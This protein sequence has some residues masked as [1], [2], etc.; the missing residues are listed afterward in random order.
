MEKEKKG[1]WRGGGVY[2]HINFKKYQITEISVVISI[3]LTFELEKTLKR[4]AAGMTSAWF[5]QGNLSFVPHSLICRL[6]HYFNRS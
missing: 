6:F 3:M 4:S 5:T 1:G 2:L